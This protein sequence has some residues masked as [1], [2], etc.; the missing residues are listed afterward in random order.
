MGRPSTS[1]TSRVTLTRDLAALTDTCG[2][3]LSMDDITEQLTPSE[4][5][6]VRRVFEFFD[7]QLST[8]DYS[9]LPLRCRR[10]RRV[11]I[12]VIN[13]TVDYN[14]VVSLVQLPPWSVFPTRLLSP[15]IH[16]LPLFILLQ[17]CE[18]SFHSHNYEPPS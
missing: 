8:F 2:L 14:R 13:V 5:G 12:Q 6:L 17:A 16:P 7:K 4:Y 1:G 11:V 15:M 18:R 10:Q 3:I 9:Y